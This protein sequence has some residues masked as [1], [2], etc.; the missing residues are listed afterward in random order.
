MLRFRCFCR[1]LEIV[2]FF[3]LVVE[4]VLEMFDEYSYYLVIVNVS[5]IIRF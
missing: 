3:V 1:E 4:V 2:K 5:L